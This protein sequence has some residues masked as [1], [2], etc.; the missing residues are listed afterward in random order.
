MRREAYGFLRM[1]SPLCIHILTDAYTDCIDIR[2]FSVPFL[3]IIRIKRK[4]AVLLLTQ[5]QVKLS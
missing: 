3:W 1:D 4:L 5:K 2:I